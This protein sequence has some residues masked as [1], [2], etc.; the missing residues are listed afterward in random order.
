MYIRPVKE[1]DLDALLLF[2]Q[3]SK[4]ELTSLSRKKN[5]L[6][7]KIEQSITSEKCQIL[8]DWQRS[9]MVLYDPEKD[10]IAGISGLEREKSCAPHYIID[11]KSK[12]LRFSTSAVSP[13][14]LG[15]LL[16]H[17]N[18]RNYG[19][20]K[21]LSKC[22][23]LYLANFSHPI[24][25]HIHAE[26]R[27]W[28][29]NNYRSPFWDNISSSFYDGNFSI[30]DQYR[31][32]YPEIFVESYLAEHE[33]PFYLIDND[34]KQKIGSVHKD[35]ENAKRMLE[36]EGFLHTSCIDILDGGPTL[37]SALK[38]VF[39]IKNSSL[40]SAIPNREKNKI[41]EIW[42]I[43]NIKVSGFRAGLYPAAH[44]SGH[45]YVHPQTLAALELDPGDLV[46]AVPRNV[47]H[48]R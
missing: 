15:S 45:L 48:Q 46:R 7:E 36:K 32:T 27:G 19:F 14:K 16:I 33:I 22:R 11:Q 6:A 39:T 21:L 12:C 3:Q 41:S 44:R 17:E 1:N 8:S 26:L 31:G 4:T 23:F 5:I 28:V 42:M 40:F 13:L 43:S 34:V 29:D 9:L 18:Y 30:I 25:D 38:N 20:G 24:A 2:L 10:S 37:K 35:T 47:A